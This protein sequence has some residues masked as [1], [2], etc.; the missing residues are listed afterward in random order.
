MIRYV[1]FDVPLLRK[2]SEYLLMNADKCR[3]PH[4]GGSDRSHDMGVPR[5]NEAF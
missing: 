2:T 1:T 5:D 4:R 3:C